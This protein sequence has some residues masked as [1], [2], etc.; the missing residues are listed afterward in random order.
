MEVDTSN[1]AICSTAHWLIAQGR[2]AALVRLARGPSVV[3]DLIR[4][5]S[6]R[7]VGAGAEDRAGLVLDCAVGGYGTV[8]EVGQHTHGFIDRHT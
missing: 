8:S 3:H 2:P 7:I 4:R 1:S 6:H 5:R